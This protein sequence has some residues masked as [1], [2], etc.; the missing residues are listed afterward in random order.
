MANF[1][2]IVQN[3]HVYTNLEVRLKSRTM[4]EQ[5]NKEVERMVDKKDLFTDYEWKIEGCEEGGINNFDSKLADAIVERI[6][7]EETDENIFWDG[8]TAH[9]D[10]N[11]AHILVSTNLQTI[12]HSST[13][14]EALAEVK[15]LRE[16][17]FEGY[18]WK[19]ENCDEDSINE[20]ED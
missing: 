11:V 3:V 20:L 15:T 13:R 18:D 1:K 6:E 12:L 5:A 16:N 7:E 4:K 8:L 17:P 9:Y 19:I 14:E 2:L 10:L